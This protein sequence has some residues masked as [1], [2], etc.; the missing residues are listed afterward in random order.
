MAEPE[1]DDSTNEDR[2]GRQDSQRY[3]VRSSILA[4]VLIIIVLGLAYLFILG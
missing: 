1:R 4:I 2:F 3:S